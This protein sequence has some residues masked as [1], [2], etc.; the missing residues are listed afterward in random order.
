[1]SA[2]PTAGVVHDL[3]IT[4]EDGDG[5]GIGFNSE[6]LTHE[7]MWDTV[8]V[9]VELQPNIFMNERLG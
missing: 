2:A 9:S 5:I 4:L 3:L 6:A 8:A 1:L 7:A